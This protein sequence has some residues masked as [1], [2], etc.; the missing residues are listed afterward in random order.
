MNKLFILGSCVSRDAFALEEG[1][2]Y[3]IVS[4][5]ARTSFAGTFH[6]QPVKDIDLSKIPSSFQQRMVENDLSKQTA[7][8]LTHNEFDWLIIDLIDERFNIFVSDNEEVFTLSPEFS[9]NCIFDKPGKV[10]TPNSDEFL[11][12]WKKGWDNF[13]DLAK[14]HQFLHKI[15]LNKV[16]WTNQTSSGGQ[17]VSDLYQSWID[18]NNRW[19]QELYSH[20]EKTGGI[21]ILEYPQEL[22]KADSDHKWGV[23]PYHYAKPLYLYLLN[24]LGRLKT[25]RKALEDNIVHTDYLPLF[26]DTLPIKRNHSAY[27][28]LVFIGGNQSYTVSIKITLAGNKQAGE[29]DLLHTL[30][31][32]PEETEWYAGQKYTLSAV[33]D[34]GYFKYI[35]TQAYTVYEREI[36]FCIP[37]GA[38][39]VFSIQEFYPKGKNIILEAEINKAGK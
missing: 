18:E 2:V 21:K 27:Q 32:E 22:F 16:F 33:K 15:I 35:A 17:V 26:M 39:A 23:Q 20:I 34:I 1:N 13:I 5:L 37:A 28:P 25:Y 24:Y 9:N 6:H 11:E 30:K 10:L 31:Y 3:H 4:Y 19:L 8:A 12:R 38:R 7:H 36:R 14:K 29:K